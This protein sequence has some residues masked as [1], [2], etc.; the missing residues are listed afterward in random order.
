MLEIREYKIAELREIFGTRDRQGIRRRLQRYGCQFEETGWG[1]RAVFNILTAPDEFKVFCITEMNVP[2][3]ADFRKM[4][5]FYYALFEDEDFIDMPDVDKEHYMSDEYEHASRQTIRNWMRYLER[6]NLIY[7]DTDDCNYYAVNKFSN[8]ERYL[9]KISRE[10]YKEGWREYW[11]NVESY[12]DTPYAFYKAS[13]VWGGAVC[14]TP[15]II[16]N[17]IEWGRTKRLKE[18]IIDS[19]IE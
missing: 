1:E 16:M 18:I 19:M 7:R 6:A 8:G 13:Q 17:A 2:A 11:E 15:K 10:T 4:K 12:G 3:Q 14:R 9:T 5:M